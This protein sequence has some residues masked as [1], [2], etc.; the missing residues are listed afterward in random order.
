M[1]HDNVLPAAAA[2][3]LHL[4]RIRALSF[5]L[6]DTLWPFRPC[7]ERA[8]ATL[9]AWLLVNAPGTAPL[10]AAPT[11]LR[12]YRARVIELHPELHT[13]LSGLRR[14]SIRALLTDAGEDPAH[15][16]TAFDVFFEERLRVELYPEVLPAL[17]RL[18][19]RFTLVGLTNGN[20]CIHK[21]GLSAHLKGSLSPATLGLAKPEAEAFHAAAALAGVD[22]AGL[23]HIG[24]DWQLDVVGA[25]G[26]GAQAAWVV[27]DADTPAQDDIALTPHTRIAD[28]TALCDALGV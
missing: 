15:A 9:L 5:D 19:R 7:I 22:A 20:G 25:V 26:A 11:A 17:D 23:L 24:D 8:E 6:D 27:R 1:Q 4:T 16:E 12:D 2:T 13:D 28:L 3:G 10:L 21:A 18:S 14:A